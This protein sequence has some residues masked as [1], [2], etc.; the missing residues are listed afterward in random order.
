MV[1][2]P[3]IEGETMAT[4]KYNS[5]ISE[6]AQTT[7]RSACRG[8]VMGGLEFAACFRHSS[9]YFLAGAKRAFPMN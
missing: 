8:P 7:L 6:R 9:S 3:M 1:F 5:K 4:S 2:N